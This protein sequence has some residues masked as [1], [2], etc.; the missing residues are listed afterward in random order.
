M[1]MPTIA[2]VLRYLKDTRAKKTQKELAI[3]I[4]EPEESVNKALERLIAIDVI[5]QEAGDYFYV[6]TPESDEF[7]TRLMEIYDKVSQKPAKEL[8]MRGLI[9]QIP[10][11]YLFHIPTLLEILEREGFDKQELD[12]FLEQESANGYLKRIRVV[13][14]GLESSII[15][16][17]IPPFYF[18]YLSQLGIIDDQKYSSLRREYKEH[19]SRE[20]D[21]LI[22]QYPPELANPAK[23]YIER[24][25]RELKDN[26]H[27]RDLVSWGGGLW[28]LV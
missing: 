4:D 8:L 12:Q 7:S 27:R 22:A 25:R 2:K 23:E 16:I 17:C 13:Y 18:H 24:E 20:E 9:C 10:S 28:K 11:Q 26:L 5:A 15:P 1:F 14:V 6:P 3:I 19:E 21:Y